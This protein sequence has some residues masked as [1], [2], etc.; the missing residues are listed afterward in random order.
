MLKKFRKWYWHGIGVLLR[1]GRL[2]QLS[3][4]EIP[5]VAK[6]SDVCEALLQD[7]FSHEEKQVLSKIDD[8]RSNLCSSEEILHFKKIWEPE[9]TEQYNQEASIAVK[10]MA[11]TAAI[12]TLKPDLC[13]ELGTNLGISAS[14]LASALQLNKSGSLVTLEGI[15]SFAQVAATG[16]EKL[17]L[18]NTTFITGLFKETLEDT[19]KKYKSF[20]YVF[21]DGHHQKGPTLEYFEQIKPFLSD[22][23]I[24]V[25]DDIYWSEGM[26]EAW[27][28]VIGEDH[29]QAA[30]DFYKLG[31][32]I[33]N[34]KKK[35]QSDKYRIAMYL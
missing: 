29:V 2:N 23:A 6:I 26:L 17:K 19:S 11:R 13:L 10:D 22:N 4:N 32:V 21:I 15:D 9:N 12:P 1:S 7:R 16:I 5:Q 31:I 25:F 14:Y 28:E 34:S 27:N 3:K 33:Y 20:D 30:I 18:S 24:V 8:L 35:K